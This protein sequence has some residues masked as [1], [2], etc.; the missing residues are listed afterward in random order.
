MF[1]PMAE[2]I[3]LKRNILLPI[4][5][6]VYICVSF[7]CMEHFLYQAAYSIYTDLSH[8]Q[9]SA[10]DPQRIQQSANT[11]LQHKLHL[12]HIS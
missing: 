9:H 10:V 7:I 3:V 4:F 5:S 12:K 6:T 11:D 1:M 2:T 8:Q